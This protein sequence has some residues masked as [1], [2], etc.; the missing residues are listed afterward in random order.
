MGFIRQ[1]EENVATRLLAWQ[2][3]RHGIDLPSQS[4]L[5][6]RAAHLVDEAHRIA[7]Q[8]GR[9]VLSIIR[10]LVDDIKKK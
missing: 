7:R 1:Q 10:E 9:N 4:V 3:Q 6:Q 8:R 2:Y 5:K